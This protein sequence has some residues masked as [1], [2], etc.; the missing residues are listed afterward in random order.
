MPSRK[1][2][3]RRSD[4]SAARFVLADDDTTMATESPAPEPAEPLASTSTPAAQSFVSDKKD[5]KK[6]KDAVTIEVRFS[7]P[8]YSSPKPRSRANSKTHG[9]RELSRI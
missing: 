4:V 3:T 1:S 5:E 8:S 7:C 9:G 2:D 6:E